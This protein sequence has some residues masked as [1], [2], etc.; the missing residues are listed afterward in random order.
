MQLSFLRKAVKTLEAVEPHVNLVTQQQHIAYPFI[1]REDEESEDAE[2]DDCS[3]EDD[4]S[5]ASSGEYEE[6]LRYDYQHNNRQLSFVS[7]PKN[8]LEVGIWKFGSVYFV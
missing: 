4:Y 5:S 7:A 6:E 3:E 8:T 1:G 2:D